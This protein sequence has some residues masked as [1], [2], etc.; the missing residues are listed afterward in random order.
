M[1]I[2]ILAAG[3]GT[4]LMPLTRNTPK[5]LLHLQNGR[6][7]L[8]TQLKKIE[9]SGVID[10]VILIIGYRGEQIEAKLKNY[11]S[12]MKIKTL[13]NPFYEM[14]N[15]LHTLWL[16]KP[17]M[18]GNFIITNGDNILEMDVYKE[19]VKKTPD[20]IVLTTNKKESYDDDDMKVILKN[21]CV[22]RVSKLIDNKKADAESVGLVKVSGGKSINIFKDTMEE[23]V[24]DK[25]YFDEFWLEIFNALS[26]KGFPIKIFEIDGEKKWQEI[27]FHLDLEKARELLGI[28]AKNKKSRRDI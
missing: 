26:S 28:A 16:S 18:D 22:E 10:E 9:E 7:V 24:R 23:L 6:S 8:E 25:D 21:N 13:Y 12:R 14:S 4:R 20:G 17:E 2:I 11:E 3:K 5:S 1:K 15:N 19:L 27:D